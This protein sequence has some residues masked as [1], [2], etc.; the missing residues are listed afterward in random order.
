MSSNTEIFYLPWNG[1]LLQLLIFRGGADLLLAVKATPC[2]FLKTYFRRP[3]LSVG[4]KLY[5][6]PHKLCRGGASNLT[7]EA[8]RSAS[9]YNCDITGIKPST[10]VH[11]CQILC[12]DLRFGV[13]WES[14]LSSPCNPPPIPPPL[15]P[16]PPLI[17]AQ[18]PPPEP[19]RSATATRIL[20]RGPCRVLQRF[21][22]G[23]PQRWEPSSRDHRGSPRQNRRNRCSARPQGSWS[24][25]RSSSCRCPA[26]SS[27]PT[28]PVRP[29]RSFLLHLYLF[30]V[31]PAHGRA[32]CEQNRRQIKTF[33][34]SSLM[35]LI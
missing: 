5:K 33:L 21:P 25:R 1:P 30:S 18:L 31:L 27:S 23:F 19:Q 2:I 32:E 24:W 22:V 13:T 35:T 16:P 28:P 4:T 10:P 12:F 6:L 3:V 11:H 34:S 8:S 7:F 26:R 29:L 15:P 20:G 14:L 17:A 9:E